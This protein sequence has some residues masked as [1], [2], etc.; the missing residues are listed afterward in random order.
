MK[1][2]VAEFDIEYYQFLDETGKP[3]SDDLPDFAT[4]VE[5]LTDMYRRMVL[6]RA[7]DKKAVVLQR[8]GKM[9]TYAPTM[10]QEAI[11]TGFG[12]LLEKEDVYVPYYRDYPAMFCHGVKLEEIYHYWGGDERG[13]DYQG[14]KED[15]PISVPIATQCLHAAGIATAIKLRKQKRMVAV[16]IGEGGT[17]EGEFYEA[18]NVAGAWQLPLV[19]F[20][21]NNQWAIS[22][23]ASAQTGA[24][25]FAQKGLASGLPCI[26]VDGN[27]ILAVHHVSKLAFERARRGEGATVIEA[28]T[29][30]LCDHTTADDATR[31]RDTDEYNDSWKREPISRLRNYLVSLNAWNEEREIAL[32]KEVN[33]EVEA[34]VERYLTVTPEPVEKMFEHLYETLPEAYENQVELAKIF[35]GKAH[36]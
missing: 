23:P 34:A 13:C 31:Y 35:G 25:T 30:R 18:V 28:L 27:D 15:F 7:F 33:Q 1:K 32:E 19:F 22:V 26:Q 9:G 16:S 24:E 6:Y 3:L 12:L 11:G 2:K 17:S 20:I 10:G 4:D 5:L 36:G 14:P 21:N 29:Y 8:T